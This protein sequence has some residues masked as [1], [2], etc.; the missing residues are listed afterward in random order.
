[1]QRPTEH[2]RRSA[3]ATRI[4]N[5][6]FGARWNPQSGELFYQYLAGK[7][8]AV[9]LKMEGNSADPPTPRELLPLP[10]GPLGNIHSQCA[11]YRVPDPLLST[12]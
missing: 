9:R 2:A 4:S 6:G 7:L 11:L 3:I 12:V 1:M 10:V 8:M 5:R